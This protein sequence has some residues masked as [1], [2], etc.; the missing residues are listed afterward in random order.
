M[1]RLPLLLLLM[2][3]PGCDLFESPDLPQTCADGDEDCDGVLGSEDCDDTRDTVFPGA[4]ERC[5]GIDDNCDGVIDEG[6]DEDADGVLTCDGDCNDAEPTV[7]T[8]AVDLCGDGL[9]NDCDG[10]SDNGEDQDED[11]DGACGSVDCDDDD[12][13]TYPDASEIC[14]LV[15][16]DCDLEIDE[17]FDLD[18]DSY[19]S[20]GGD[21]DD[22]DDTIFPGAVEICDGV[23]QDCDGGVDTPIEDFDEDEDGALVCADGDCDDDDDTVFVG[24]FEIADG[25]DEDCDGVIDDGWE[26]TGPASLY[27]PTHAPA[28]VQGALGLVLSKAGDLNG[29]GYPDF[30]AGAPTWNFSRGRVYVWLGSPFDLDDA[31][32]FRAPDI[33]VEGES[34]GLGLG[35]GVALA[36]LDDDGYDDLVI[37]TPDDGPG[38]TPQGSIRIYWGSATPTLGNWDE[39][40]F[41]HMFVGAHSVERCGTAL[42]NAGDVDGDGKD[43]LLVGCPWYTLNEGIVGRTA[44]ISGR[45][46]SLWALVG[47]IEDGDATYVGIGGEDDYSSSKV[48]GNFDFNGD[49]AMDVAVASGGYNAGAG[50]VAVFFG[51]SGLST[52][53]NDLDDGDRVYAGGTIEQVGA[54]LSAGDLDGDGDDELFIGAPDFNNQRGR[55]AIIDGAS[56]PAASGLIWDAASG[57]YDGG[58]IGNRSSTAVV[59][60]LNGDDVPDLLVGSQGWDGPEGGDQGKVSVI[61]GP[62]P[63]GILTEGDAAAII[64][65]TEGGD[66]LGAN[67]VAIGDAN[68]DDQ[69]DVLIAA[70][71]SDGAANGSGELFFVP[72][73]P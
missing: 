53:W 39:D 2:A 10:V 19:T 17:G 47:D 61:L 3:L 52:G 54:F 41:D 62:V 30:A 43:D 57:W 27:A 45:S 23:D 28:V 46:R 18:S 58:A 11:A 36:D 32:P 7:Y 33:T 8:G 26:G 5:N 14:D 34:D 35:Q 37:G 63:G 69:D 13:N 16:N 73:F 25:R 50:R 68:G 51:G 70:P 64:V 71:Y 38:S 22:T 24:A 1:R 48:L 49:G 55:L 56:S 12:P 40:D 15:D 4:T 65:G 66:A 67:F 72:G 42:S 21:C 29:D 59:A 44:L 9:D 20:C 6:Y 31:P 60:E